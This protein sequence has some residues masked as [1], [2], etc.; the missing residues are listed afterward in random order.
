MQA[1]AARP[2]QKGRQTWR[3]FRSE[4]AHYFVGQ[5]L[6]GEVSLVVSG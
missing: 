2:K 5:G 3:P 1:S 6:N 4:E